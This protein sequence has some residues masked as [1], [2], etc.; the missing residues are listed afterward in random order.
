VQ[1]RF[2]L[3][4]KLPAVDSTHGSITLPYLDCLGKKRRAPNGNKTNQADRRR[5]SNQIGAE[6]TTI[7]HNPALGSCHFSA[8]ARCKVAA[9]IINPFLLPLPSLPKSAKRIG[10]SQGVT[11]EHLQEPSSKGGC[12]DGWLADG[13]LSARSD[14]R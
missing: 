2:E 5:I 13:G 11:S 10:I 14:R 12:Y 9:E 1:H 8:D 6:M 7:P 4:Q 3:S